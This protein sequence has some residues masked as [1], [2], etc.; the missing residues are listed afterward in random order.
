MVGQLLRSGLSLQANVKT[1]ETGSTRT[2]LLTALA[3][4]VLGS[5]M[6]HFRMR[7]GPTDLVP[8]QATASPR[9]ARAPDPSRTSLPASAALM[10][11]ILVAI[12]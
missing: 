1:S 4:G 6:P 3:L 10:A 9:S 2:V 7:S 12:R 5:M 8:V 11:G